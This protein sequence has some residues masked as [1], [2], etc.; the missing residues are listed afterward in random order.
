MGNQNCMEDKS[1]S[2]AVTWVDELV[3][4]LDG[5]TNGVLEVEVGGEKISAIIG[6]AAIQFF[7]DNKP[8]LI[9]LGKDLFKSFLLLLSEKK[10]EQAFNLILA[11]MDADAIIARM[12]MNA[13]ELHNLNNDHDQ[14]IVALKKWALTALTQAATKILI[15]LLI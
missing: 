10:E 7:K 6:T 3:A 9:R 13:S 14:F 2:S 15:G 12:T 8:L 1:I 5:A 11:K 4:K